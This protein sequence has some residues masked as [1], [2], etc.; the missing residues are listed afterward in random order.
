MMRIENQKKV[1]AQ[2]KQLAREQLSRTEDV[3]SLA[4]GESLLDGSIV[5]PMLAFIPGGLGGQGIDDI[6]EEVEDEQDRNAQ[7]S[8]SKARKEINQQN[9]M[10]KTGPNFY[11][12]T[13]QTAIPEPIKSEFDSLP[14]GRIALPF[15]QSQMRKTNNSMAVS[16]MEDDP[17]DALT[18]EIQDQRY[19]EFLEGQ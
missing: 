14:P 10:N 18:K 12:S 13:F 15:E 11:K 4:A 8:P 16:L 5:D 7:T 3:R 19:L 1:S 6:E 9:E 17:I 2:L